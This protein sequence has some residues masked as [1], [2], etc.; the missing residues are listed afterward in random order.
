MGCSGTK[1]VGEDSQHKYENFNWDE[2]L[3]KLPAKKTE[4]DKKI[5]NDLWKKKLH[6]GTDGYV[7]KEQVE[8]VMIGYLDLPKE[9]LQ[10]EPLRKAFEAA[11]A[12]CKNKNDRKGDEYLQ[13]DEFRFYF[14]YLRQYFEYWVMFERVDASGD[15]QISFEEFNNAL[16]KMKEWGVE[17]TD[18]KTEFD[19]IDYSKN[20]TISFDEFCAYAIRKSLDLEDDDDFDDEG[21][22]QLKYLNNQ[23]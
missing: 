4:E 12:K 1:S 15:H 22:D 7:T 8:K 2:L 17:I 11:K 9:I 21:L 18:A 5:R 23:N 16:P 13:K 6:S 10:K 3:N 14:V 20:G 19:N